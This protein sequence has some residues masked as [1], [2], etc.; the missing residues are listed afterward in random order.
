[1]IIDLV[2]AMLIAYGFYQG[3]SKGLIKTVFS[4]LSVIIAIVAALKLSPILISILQNAININPA[5]NFVLGFV[6]TFIIVMA[7]IRFIGNKLDKLMKSIHIGGVNK[8]LGGA[9]LGLFYA[10]LIS[11]GIYFMDRVQL[12]SDSQKSAS[13]T[14][15]VLET[16]PRATQSMG[17]SLKPVFKDFWEAMIDTMD[18][19][20]AST[21]GDEPAES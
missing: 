10:I 17:E 13:F 6:L 16:L 14:Y 20:K 3:F 18:S 12:I 15:P 11:Y 7:L 2:A 5:I 4:T 19:I 21:T 1:M 9:L 8:V